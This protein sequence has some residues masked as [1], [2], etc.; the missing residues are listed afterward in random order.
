MPYLHNAGRRHSSWKALE[1]AGQ[2]KRI[3][4][5]TCPECPYSAIVRAILA[6]KRLPF[7]RV[8]LIPGVHAAVLRLLQFPENTVP[9]LNIAGE[10]VH[11]TIAAVSALERVYPER[12]LFPADPDHRRLVEDITRWA[13]QTIGPIKNDLYWWGMVLDPAAVIALWENART[14]VPKTILRRALPRAVRAFGRSQPPD[15]EA[16]MRRLATVPSLL[17]HIDANIDAGIIGGL[18]LNAGDFHAGMVA[19]LLMSLADLEPIVSSR[20]AGA[21]AARTYTE[22]IAHAAPFL[23]REQKRALASP[24]ERQAV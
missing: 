20:P 4:L 3:T 11:S 24:A 15:T 1:P 2:A 7:R 12:P 8:D 16:G 5:Y 23:S 9:A 13:R 14:G 17:Q 6:H 19:R 10:R 18:E 22:P 21:L